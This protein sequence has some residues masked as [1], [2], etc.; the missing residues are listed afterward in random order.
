MKHLKS[1]SVFVT[2]IS[3]SILALATSANDDAIAERLQPVGSVCLA[4]ECVQPEGTT[5]LVI[6]Q[7]AER[8][9][10]EVYTTKCNACHGTGA[11]NAPK[12]GDKAAWEPRIAKGME[13]LMNNV[14][15]GITD[16]GMMPPKGIC[17]DCSDSELQAATEYMINQAQ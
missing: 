15:N 1:L 11:G 4:G 12:L 7:G 14:I 16:V 8:S 2:T 17:M 13:T 6:A 9:G 10:E 5:A 3:L